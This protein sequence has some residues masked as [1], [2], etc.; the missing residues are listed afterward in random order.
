M[1]N[2]GIAPIILV[3]AGVVALVG[4]TAGGAYLHKTL[5]AE[6]P[7][8]DFSQY[9]SPNRGSCPN[10]IYL[11]QGDI[12]PDGGAFFSLNQRNC[13]LG[14]G[15]KIAV[16]LKLQN[17]YTGNE[18]L[19][20]N[21]SG[22][23]NASINDLEIQL[24]Y[25]G[26]VGKKNRDWKIDDDFR[27]VIRT[28]LHKS[29][30]NVLIREDKR[31][32]SP[33]YKTTGGEHHHI[34]NLSLM[35]DE[36][37]GERIKI[38]YLNFLTQPKFITA[39]KNIALAGIRNARSQKVIFEAEQRKAAERDKL[40]LENDADE[41][42]AKLELKAK[43]NKCLNELKS[44]FP[45]QLREGEEFIYTGDLS[46]DC[47]T[48]LSENEL[49][50]NSRYHN[51]TRNDWTDLTKVSVNTIPYY[52]NNN[53]E[54]FDKILNDE[55]SNY[56]FLSLTL[57]DV[58]GED[59]SLEEPIELLL[60]EYTNSEILQLK[61]D[62][63]QLLDT[64][65]INSSYRSG[66]DSGFDTEFIS[67]RDE[68][69]RQNLVIENGFSIGLLDSE[70]NP[71]ND[72]DLT[73]DKLA[74]DNI[75]QGDYTIIIGF[76]FLDEYVAQ[77]RNIN[78]LEPVMSNKFIVIPFSSTTINSFESWLSSTTESEFRGMSIKEYFENYINFYYI[79]SIGGTETMG[80][81]IEVNKEY[82]D[83]NLFIPSN[84]LLDR[85][86]FIVVDDGEGKGVKTK[87]GK[88]LPKEEHL[89]EEVIR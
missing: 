39:A 65:R 23:D 53:L 80:A 22:T 82:I 34:G 89:V 48:Y 61:N 64:F 75:P 86:I 21:L 69:I 73:L 70:G 57:R 41:D 11:Y 67:R 9:Y 83:G 88:I 54:N 59:V 79:R 81:K 51:G 31:Y 71:V 42:L 58:F 4:A 18:N 36:T 19:L 33:I 3:I 50:I 13:T 26:Y 56:V 14:V 76:N 30:S 40:L 49:F 47:K 16:H 74:F 20:G 77:E 17:F 1:N 62:I 5:T 63:K 38:N 72:V 24:F 10:I 52:I 44:I 60:V 29:N 87:R 66:G 2:K 85:E 45:Q 8:L 46:D 37:T 7:D 15:D 78:V 12:A 68:L 27:L 35:I 6:D 84:G 32:D 43:S 25:L 55:D 28:G